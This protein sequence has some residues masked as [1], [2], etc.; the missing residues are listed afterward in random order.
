V[1]TLTMSTNVW[2]QYTRVEVHG[3][4]GALVARDTSP[5]GQGRVTLL[6][7]GEEPEDVTGA[8]PNSWVA[9]LETVTRAASGEDVDYASGEDGARNLEI[10]EQIID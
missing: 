1:A 4:G 10:M 6:R 3:T 5:I 9:Q 8:R 2:V 7:A